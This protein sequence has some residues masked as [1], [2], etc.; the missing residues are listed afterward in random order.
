[1]ARISVGEL[2]VCN[3]AINGCMR[4]LCLFLILFRDPDA[5]KTVCKVEK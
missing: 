2:Q 3:W 5:R 4:K 1:M